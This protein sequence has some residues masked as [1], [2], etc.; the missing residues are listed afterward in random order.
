MRK[1]Y[2]NDFAIEIP[3]VLNDDGSLNESQTNTNLE[4][5]YEIHKVHK[6]TYETYTS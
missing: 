6:E 4:A 2:D 3:A 5:T 1:I